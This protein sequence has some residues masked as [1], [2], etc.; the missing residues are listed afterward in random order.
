MER[1]T[2]YFDLKDE[3]FKVIPMRQGTITMSPPT[4][5]LETMV[6]SQRLHHD[7]HP[8]L[9][10]NI[11]NLVVKTNATGDIK[12]DKEKAT[13]KIDGCVAM[14]MAIDRMV[15]NRDFVSVYETRGFD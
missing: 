4:K 9:R 7:G 14:I 15:R 2:V 3:G 12:P 10:W 6:L 1:Y 8:V 5:E 13:Q 11:D